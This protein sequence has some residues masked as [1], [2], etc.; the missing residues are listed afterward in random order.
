MVSDDPVP[1]T[2]YAV[3][4]CGPGKEPGGLSLSMKGEPFEKLRDAEAFARVVG[5]T[6]LVIK[7][8]PVGVYRAGRVE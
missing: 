2:M 4:R 6:C 1:P 5:G 7:L 3:F 8:L